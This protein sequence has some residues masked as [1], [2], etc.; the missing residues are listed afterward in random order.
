[1]P[2]VGHEVFHIWNGVA[3]NFS[4]Q[5]YWFSEGFTEYYSRITSARLGFTSE[6]DFLRDLERACELYLSKSGELSIREAGRN[7]S[8]NMDLVYQGG[9]LIAATLDVQI[10]KLTQNQK[11]LDDVMKLSLIHI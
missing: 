3:I 5:E 10:R 1:M 6:N 8:A 7:K 11:S 2:L 9:N 4:E